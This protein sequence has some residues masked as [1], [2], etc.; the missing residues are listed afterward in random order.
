VTNRVLSE[1]EKLAANDAD[2]YDKVWENFGAVLKEGLY[3]DFERRETLLGLTRFTTSSSEGKRRSLKDYLGGLKANQTAIYYATGSDLDRLATS[4]QLEG[5][6]ARGIEVLLLTD[7]VDSFWVTSGLDCEGKPFK[8]ITQGVADLNLIPLPDGQPRP[9]DASGEVTR[10]IEF[11]K[12]TLG[13]AV[14][15]VRASDRLTESPVCLVAAD[16]GIDRQ[17]EK[18]LASAGRLPSAS[19]PVLEINPQHELVAALSQLSDADHVFREDAA[20]LL[21]D[22]AKIADGEAPIDAKAFSGRLGRLMSR[23]LESA[24]S[25]AP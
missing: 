5:F 11:V 25:L 10:F 23:A 16:H 15:D 22:E 19:K 17:L 8:S 12:T 2:A 6:R 13:E 21:F 24:V 3:E 4:P 7:Q 14:S 9:A 1:L 20:R 18:L